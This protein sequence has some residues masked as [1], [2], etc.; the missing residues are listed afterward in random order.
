MN[1]CNLFFH[2]QYS[3]QIEVGAFTSTWIQFQ[4]KSSRG[5]GVIISSVYNTCS[6]FITKHGVWCTKGVPISKRQRNKYWTL[7]VLEPV[8]FEMRLHLA[9]ILVGENVFLWTRIKVG[10]KIL[11]LF[12][13][14]KILNDLI[15][16][17]RRDET[18][19]N[20]YM[21]CEI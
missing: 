10:E 20:V 1:T 21:E 13:K 6:V 19:M 7:H 16:T 4:L 8:M 9:W 17:V 11:R 3:C 14:N 15:E 2:S 12:K 18:I 5:I